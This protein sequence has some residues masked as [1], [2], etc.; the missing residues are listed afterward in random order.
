MSVNLLYQLKNNIHNLVLAQFCFI[1]HPGTL[2]LFLHLRRCSTLAVSPAHLISQW[3]HLGTQ[4]FLISNQPS[5]KAS[6]VFSPALPDC[7]LF[8]CEK[9]L[10]WQIIHCRAYLSLTYLLLILC[11]VQLTFCQLLP[12]LSCSVQSKPPGYL[13]PFPGH[14]L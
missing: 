2:S 10:S 9:Q 11:L 7:S 8:K 4:V 14:K 13:A 3:I 1:A 12:R 5:L 6:P